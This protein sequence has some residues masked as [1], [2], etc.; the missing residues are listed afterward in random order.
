MTLRCLP[1]ALLMLLCGCS[2]H[3][4]VLDAQGEAAI[5]LKDLIIFVALVAAVIWLAVVSVMAFALVRK[6]SQS[7]GLDHRS[8]RMM[9]I[10][11][12]TAT[13]AT[14]L[15][16]GVLTVASFYTTRALNSGGDAEVT[17]VV[18]GQ[19]WWWQFIYAD[20]DQRPI[21]Q[22]ANELHI[23]VG[24]TIRLRLQAADVIHSFWVPSLAGKLDLIPGRE[25]ILT[26]RAERPGVYR[27]Q[28]AEFCGLQHSHMAF[29]VVA[30]DDADY[31]HWLAGQRRD[32]AAPS[33]AEA[34]AGKAIFLAKPCAACHTIRGTSASGSTGP[35]LTHVGSR[36]TI[37]AGLLEITRGSLAAWI[38]DPQ[39]LKPGN[40]MPIVP[41]TADELRQLSAYME[42]LR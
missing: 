26:L 32:G 3:Q 10:A 39:T 25:N 1:L 4:S 36:R 41:L 27:G 19:Q 2:S 9:T 7:A 23:P 8:E 21:F 28:C 37:A 30:E 33:G 16:V 18:R 29:V 42:S 14:A 31:Q 15:V 24:K 6:N 40:N 12:A 17:V 35:D 20:R 11:V 38:A 5:A 22:T 34:I 13:A